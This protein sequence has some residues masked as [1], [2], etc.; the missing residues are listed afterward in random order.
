MNYLAYRCKF[1][2]ANVGL[3]MPSNV[4]QGNVNRQKINIHLEDIQTLQGWYEWLIL[5][6]NP[7]AIYQTKSEQV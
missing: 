5:S 1:K 2:E 4:W 6:L 7:C 3:K